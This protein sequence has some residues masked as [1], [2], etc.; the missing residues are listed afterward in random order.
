MIYE[1]SRY[2]RTPVVAAA[3]ATG[4]EPRVL[5]RRVAPPAPAALE[6]TVTDG[7]RLDHLAERFYGEPTRYWL[8]L[9]AN[10][11]VLN[12]FHLLQ[13]GRRIAVP[14]NRVLDR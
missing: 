9:D 1:G 12:P 7:E 3:D 11:E 4:R 10:P 2:A 13:P 6:H 8:I 5:A 14:R